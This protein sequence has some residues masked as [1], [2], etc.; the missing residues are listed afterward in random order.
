MKIKQIQISG[1][2]GIPPVTPPNVDIKLYDKNGLSQD[3]LLFGPNAYGKSSI[4]DALE[5]FFKENVRCNTYFEDYASIDNVHMYL[6]K[7][8]YGEIAYIELVIVH[9]K[10]EHK[11]RKELGQD[12]L[13][14][15]ED[16]GDIQV[17]LEK[18]QD[19]IIV[20]D[21]DQF[22]NFVAAA[23]KDKWRTFSSLIGLEELDHFRT[24]LDSITT[25]SLTD[26]LSV[27]VLRNEI[28]SRE[29]RWE[30]LLK[31][32]LQDNDVH[33]NK[34]DELVLYF[35]YLIEINCKSL[36]VPA[37]KNNGINNDFWNRLR[38]IVSSPEDVQLAADRVSRL[39]SQKES[40]IPFEN[41]FHK[42]LTL[43]KRKTQLLDE[44]K[45]KFD[46]ELLDKFYKLGLQLLEHKKATVDE[47][48]FCSTPY[49]WGELED[50]VGRKHADLD[51]ESIRS[52][53][54][55]LWRTWNAIKNTI[56]DRQSDFNRS[57]IQRIQDIFR[58]ISNF[59][60]ID[61][62]LS[63]ESFDLKKIVNWL[64]N[65]DKL[66]EEM[67]GH[68]RI[69]E[70]Q[71]VESRSVDTNPQEELQRA[72]W[73]MERLWRNIG[74]LQDEKKSIQKLRKK[75]MITQD[76]VDA[77]RE[78]ASGFRRELND[79]SGRVATNITND[80]QIYYKELHPGD[81]VIPTLEVS[82]SGQQRT[83]SLKCSY[84]GVQDRTAAALLSESHRNSLGMAILLA[85]M[86]FKRQLGS[87][88]EFCVFDDVTQSFDVEHRTNL[89]ALLENPK[90]P[91]IYDQ[92]ILFFTH[93]RTLADLVKR[94]GDNQQR[95]NW[96]RY[97]IRYWWLQR[98]LVE[99]EN[100]G[101]PFKRAE[102][103]IK[104]GDEIAAAVYTRLGLERLYKKIIEE[105][106]M[107]IP[108]T[109]KPWNV[110]PDKYRKYIL[111]ELDELWSTGKGFIDPNNV[112]LRS[113][114]TSQRILNF[115]VH[116]SIFLDN[117]MTIGDVQNAIFDIRKLEKYFNCQCGKWYHS[118][119]KDP[120]TSN[121]PICR[122]HGCG[123]SLV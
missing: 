110:G 1:F 96:I 17:E 49:Q 30:N 107:R 76:T 35:T 18:A 45:G 3:L 54:Q 92:Q 112:N 122:K 77:I 115:C 70:K 90:Y 103:Y 113:L 13:K 104:E 9:N 106:G 21:H 114:L 59:D 33:G 48:P 95:E 8:E 84:K 72:V 83:V 105:T 120:K 34:L 71:I 56:R 20:L 22:R 65:V 94:A 37:P 87:S 97:D 123:K 27:D 43:L 93:D 63:L 5:W 4:A 86:K 116:D 102:A 62:A 67:H 121:P 119:R 19:E 99:S 14:S 10:K 53:H 85:F 11:I 100:E 81:D 40:L 79:F 98:M 118:V 88:I 82:I 57:G 68:R 58:E 16:L 91:E 108:F 39:K 55:E 32:S 111:D 50:H 109:E 51:F 52:E 75:L 101:E 36:D 28:S 7:P 47:C 6:G 46:K 42:G 61:V 69:I 89:L 73:Q 2:R 25:K 66:I 38:S 23:N 80:V 74:E 60:D 26:A 44:K 117:P 41:S 24:G 12:G 29:G 15:G 78:A 64:N 31:Q